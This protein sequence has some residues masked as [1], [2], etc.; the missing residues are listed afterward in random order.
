[1]MTWTKGMYQNPTQAQLLAEKARKLFNELNIECKCEAGRSDD[2][3]MYPFYVPVTK[4]CKRCEVNNLLYLIQDPDD[5]A[6]TF[7]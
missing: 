2:G 5:K 6:S 4:M 7:T 3:E 1:M